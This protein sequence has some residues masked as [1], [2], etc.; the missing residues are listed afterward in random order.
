M[1]KKAVNTITAVLIITLI[2]FSSLAFQNYKEEVF[3]ELK[4]QRTSLQKF[5]DTNPLVTYIL[6]FTL[7]IF[8]VNTPVPFAATIKVIGGMIFGIAGG[9]IMNILATTLG[10]GIG[11]FLGKYFIKEHVYHKYSQKLNKID[12][13]FHNNSF[14]YI[15]LMRI[16]LV[17]PFFIIN[18]ISGAT[19]KIS[20]KDY[21]LST[22]IGVIPLSYV[23]A[24][25]GFQLA[26]INSFDELLTPQ[27]IAILIGLIILLGISIIIKNKFKKKRI[28]SS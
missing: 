26:T 19:R 7:T 4:E 5:T 12:K 9:T 1:P 21:L 13:E 14:L 10:A 22:I 18:F 11:F 27:T 23:Y 15:I 16:S 28:I 3:Q 17:V 8:L 2:F 6:F 24:Y 20:F 25:A